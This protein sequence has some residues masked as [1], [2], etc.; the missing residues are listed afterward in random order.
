MHSI[1]APST[2]IIL[3]TGANRGIGFS[4]VLQTALRDPSATFILACRSVSSGH[5]AVNSL[6]DQGVVTAALDVVEMD[7]TVDSSIEAAAEYVKTKYGRLDGML[8][9]FE[10]KM[11]RL[12]C[13]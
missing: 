1:M 7:I 8:R 12:M 6:R 11:V 4:I 9:C 5:K 2:Q 13:E 3:V 10:K